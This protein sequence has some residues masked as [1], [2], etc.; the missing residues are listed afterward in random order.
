MLQLAIPSAT[1]ILLAFQNAYSVFLLS[2]PKVQTAR[3]ASTQNS[4]SFM[5]TVI[6]FVSLTIFTTS[7]A[8]GQVMFKRVGLAI[9]PTWLMAYCLC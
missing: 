5:Q 9:R 7:L 3:L 1:A 6:N 8:M 4:K 2:V